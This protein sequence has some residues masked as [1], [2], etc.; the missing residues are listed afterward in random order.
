MIVGGRVGINDSIIAVPMDLQYSNLDKLTPL[1]IV[2]APQMVVSTIVEAA[3]VAAGAHTGNINMGLDGTES[4]VW[5]AVNID[6]Q[7]WS[8]LCENILGS[9]GNG[10]VTFPD[11]SGKTTAYGTLGIPAMAM[12]LGVACSVQGLTAPTTFAEA[13]AMK[14]PCVANMT[15]RV[16][17]S[18][19]TDNAT[20][21]IRIIRIWR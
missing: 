12:V 18:H 1:P 21:T 16:L 20:V 7:P 17:N 11:Y 5:I 2:S 3:T 9:T 6:K 4:E 13:R 10:G 19:A 15:C 14:L 8:L